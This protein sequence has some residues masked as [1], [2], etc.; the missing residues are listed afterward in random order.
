MDEDVLDAG[1]VFE[2]MIEG[3]VPAAGDAVTVEIDVG[4]VVVFARPPF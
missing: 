4:K 1:A 3:D 2:V